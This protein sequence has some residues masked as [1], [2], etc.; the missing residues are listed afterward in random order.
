MMRNIPEF[1]FWK[2]DQ[3]F[4]LPSLFHCL[5]AMILGS[6]SQ[7]LD[8]FYLIFK[9]QKYILFYFIFIEK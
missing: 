9:M 7:W 6:A 2:E 4:A 8:S 5:Y 3:T 1:L